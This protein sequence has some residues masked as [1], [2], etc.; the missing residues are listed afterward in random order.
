MSK[1]DKVEVTPADR[2]AAKS[3]LWVR[4]IIDDIESIEQAFARH[5]IATSLWES[6]YR[7]PHP[8]QNGR[9]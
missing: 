9:S 2:E 1:D 7:P 3:I 4:T 8:R 5:R 6:P